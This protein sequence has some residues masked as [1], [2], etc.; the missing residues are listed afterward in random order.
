M[1]KYFTSIEIVEGNYI[2]TVFDGNNNQEL[3]KSKGYPT[4]SQAMQD[5]NTYLITQN[6]PKS[7]PT[8]NPVTQTIVNTT[9]R[10]VSMPSS[11][12]RCCGR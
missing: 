10:S 1:K 2:G 4:Q 12:R 9:V 11:Q 6:P 7:D 3:Y 8:P 5:V